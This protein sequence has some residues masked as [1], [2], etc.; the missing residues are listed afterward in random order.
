LYPVVHHFY[1]WTV[2]LFRVV[3]AQKQFGLARSA[4]A[5]AQRR[6]GT[7][8]LLDLGDRVANV[9]VVLVGEGSY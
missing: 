4:G 1:E 9:V 7:N 6:V 3:L 2:S 8:V 5:S